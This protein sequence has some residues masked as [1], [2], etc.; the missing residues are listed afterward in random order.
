MTRIFVSR[1]KLRFAQPF[2][3]KLKWTTNWSVYSQGFY[4]K[5]KFF[6]VNT[7]EFSVDLIILVLQYTTFFAVSAVF[8]LLFVYTGE[9]FPTDI[10]ATCFAICSLGGR[11]G[12]LIAPQ[13]AKLGFISAG[14]PKIVFSLLMFA[15]YRIW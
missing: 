7:N 10:R 1:F 3:A 11:F 6:K 15:V 2:L 14:I 12:S 5:N 13:I 4:R 8:A 9:M